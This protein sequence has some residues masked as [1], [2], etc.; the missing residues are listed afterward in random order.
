MVKILKLMLA[1]I[2]ALSLLGFVAC[3]DDPEEKTESM[4]I[5]IAD[6]F[7]LPAEGDIISDAVLASYMEDLNMTAAAGTPADYESFS[8]TATTV[9]KVAW[10]WNPALK[11]GDGDWSLGWQT[12]PEAQAGVTNASLTALADSIGLTASAMDV[13]INYDA[14]NLYLLA[15]ISDDTTSRERDIAADALEIFIDWENDDWDI[16]NPEGTSFGSE[17][18]NYGDM[19][20][21]YVVTLKSGNYTGEEGDT[22]QTAGGS[23]ATWQGWDATEYP[24]E[25]C[26]VYLDDGVGYVVYMVI[27]SPVTL[28][29]GDEIGIDFKVTDANDYT[30]TWSSNG[31]TSWAMPSSF[32]TLTLE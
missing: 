12:G 7:T 16:A 11:D 6:N 3:D 20:G 14:D 13:T 29:A 25:T 17:W 15:V 24:I 30:C 9:N 21:Q 28:A 18:A 2:V 8:G 26:K 22:V 4:I 32:G 10:V 19:D 23:N 27:P 1:L 5:D 31:N